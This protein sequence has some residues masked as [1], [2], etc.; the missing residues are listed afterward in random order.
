[1]LHFE[2]VKYLVQNGADVNEKDI[3]NAT[4]LKFASTN[5]HFEIMK[6][7]IKQIL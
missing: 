3:N 1:M 7:L 6:Y 5:N 2:I 4:A